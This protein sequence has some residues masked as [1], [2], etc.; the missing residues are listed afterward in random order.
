[1]FYQE[2]SVPSSQSTNLLPSHLLVIIRIRTLMSTIL[3]LLPDLTTTHMAAIP[4]HLLR[5]I[6]PAWLV[7]TEVTK[8]R[9]KTLKATS[10]DTNGSKRGRRRRREGSKRDRHPTFHLPAMMLLQ[11]SFLVIV[12]INFLLTY[13]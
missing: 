7:S 6:S 5:H 11:V 2:N 3:L 8:G 9:L 13:R 10:T 12:P 1:M 4:L